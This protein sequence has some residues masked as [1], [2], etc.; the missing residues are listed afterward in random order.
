M[1]HSK[2]LVFSRR[3]VL[4]AGVWAGIGTALPAS[5]LAAG[6][7]VA[8]QAV[9]T[10]AI[11][12]S[13][14][15]VPVMGIGTNQFRSANYVELR[16]VLKRMTALGG[17][18][19]DTA[20]MYDNGESEAVIGRALAELGLRKKM[21]IATKFNAPG[22][23]QGASSGGPTRDS[24]SGMDSVVRSLR[25]L[26]TGQI[27][28]LMAHFLSSVE[29]LMPIMQ[30]LKRTGRVRYIGITS[31]QVADYPQ[32]LEYMRKYPIDFV[33]V[34][35]SLG[36]RAAAVDVLPLAKKRRIAVMVAEPLGGG[37]T[38]LLS[39]VQGR[40]LPKWA[41]TFNATSWS[42]F[43]L[44]YVVS[45]PTVTCAIPGSSKVGHLE[46]N[47]AAGHGPLPDTAMRKMMEEFWDGNS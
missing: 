46:D 33:Q 47:Q 43:F 29:P 41:A 38:S 34:G 27:D 44:K 2:H 11:P 19:I 12:S 45:H 13:R 6:A 22:A 9:I 1:A 26:Q 21:F 23:S 10:R 18:V 5:V 40:E 24:V 37:R 35:Y 36:D 17:S 30:E 3:D 14:E 31:V 25:R 8:T 15:R 20:G 39:Q 16:D 32:L 7:A 28:L 42:Q 4:Q